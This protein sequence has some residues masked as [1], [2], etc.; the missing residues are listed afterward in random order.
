MRAYILPLAISLLFI[1]CNP[2][3]VE[4]EPEVLQLSITNSESFESTGSARL[5]FEIT[6]DKAPEVDVDVPYSISGISAEPGVDFLGSDGIVTIPAGGFKGTL[7]IEVVNDDIKEVDEKMSVT[8]SA[9]TNFELLNEVG[10]GTI[11]DD[12][13]ISGVP[14]D[15]Y[16]TS[17]SHFG[18]ELVW[19]DEFDGESLDLDSYTYELG[20]GCPNLCGWGNNELQAYTNLAENVYLEDSKLIIK[21]TDEGHPSYNSARIITKGKKEFKFGRIDVRAKM[22]KGQGLWPAI[23][24]LGKN[25]DQVGWPVCGEIDIMELVGHKPKTAHGTAHWGAPGDGFSTSSSGSYSIENDFRDEFHVFSI[26]WEFNEIVWYVDETKFQRVTIDNMQGKP[27]P[28]NQ[29]FFFIFN[30]AVGGQ[31]PGSPDDTTEFPQTME[32]DYVRMFQ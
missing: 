30:V 4:P 1:A 32:I 31:W 21:A 11:K 19:E 9:P 29:D 7:E 18:Y 27:Y 17:D 12:D 2:T 15:G 22:P 20:D 28:F 24:M 3:A 25:I 8:I 26:V 16:I 13:Q 23:W 6:V 14:A 5:T 10:V